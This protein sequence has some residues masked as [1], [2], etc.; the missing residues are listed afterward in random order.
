MGRLEGKLAFIIGA[1]GRDS[2]TQ[3][4]RE[5]SMTA[6]QTSVTEGDIR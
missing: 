4:P 1:A 3:I 5:A 2:M 6:Q